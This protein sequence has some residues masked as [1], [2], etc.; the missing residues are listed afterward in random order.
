MNDFF[1]DKVNNLKSR[2]G[3]TPA[4]FEHCH[5]AMNGKDCKLNMKHVTKKKV[6]KILKNLK[7]SKSL[8]ID[9][10]S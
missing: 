2:F 5:K 3:D 4:N 9:E 6:L 10:L 1:I 7:S 8:G